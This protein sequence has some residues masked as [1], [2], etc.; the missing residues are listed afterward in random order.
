MLKKYLLTTTLIAATLFMTGCNNKTD[1]KEAESNAKVAAYVVAQP[2]AEAKA[3]VKDN[4]KGYIKINPSVDFSTLNVDKKDKKILWP[5][6]KFAKQVPAFTSGHVAEVINTDD[7]FA[8]YIMNVEEKDF[9]AYYEKLANA[10][11]QFAA[12]NQNWENF[13][14]S[15]PTVEINLRFGQDGPTVTTLRAKKVTPAP[16]KK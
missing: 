16:A 9:A 13:T 2:P 4:T 12:K 10:G 8:A 15:T 7:A 6:D 3:G 5:Q 11:F 14:M 1:D